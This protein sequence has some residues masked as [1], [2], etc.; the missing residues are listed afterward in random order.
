M[1]IDAL[2]M[3]GVSIDSQSFDQSIINQSINS[4]KRQAAQKRKMK[5]KALIKKQKDDLDGSI[6]F[7]DQ[8]EESPMSSKHKRS[9]KE[10]KK[11]QT[12]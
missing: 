2:D 1:R 12:P 10:E 4:G 7:R 3:L 8:E 6:I 9:I 5:E 11:G